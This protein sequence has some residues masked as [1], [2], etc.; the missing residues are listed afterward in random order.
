VL[1]PRQIVKLTDTLWIKRWLMK[2]DTG[3]RIRVLFRGKDL[4]ARFGRD[5]RIQLQGST[6]LKLQGGQAGHRASFLPALAA[7]DPV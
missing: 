6:G 4:C 7:D 2:Q 3:K 1:T 5:S